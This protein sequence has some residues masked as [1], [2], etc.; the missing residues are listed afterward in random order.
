MKLRAENAAAD[1]FRIDI[2][3]MAAMAAPASSPIA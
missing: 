3:L 2:L 1:Y